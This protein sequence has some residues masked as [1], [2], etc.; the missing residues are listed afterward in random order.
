MLSR[1]SVRIKVM[2]LL[3]ALGRDEQLE[4]N[5]LRNRY[6]EMVEET[7]E[8]LFFTLYAI[9][10][11]TRHSVEDKEK[12]HSKHLPSEED[13]NFSDKFYNNARSG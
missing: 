1:R 4:F 8:L 5:D 13:K 2:Q 10:Q 11:I 12:R 3:F 9:V 7:F 6:N